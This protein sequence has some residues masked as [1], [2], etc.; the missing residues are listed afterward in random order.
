MDLAALLLIL[1]KYY[2]LYWLFDYD[3]NYEYP[4]K[5][6]EMTVGVGLAQMLVY[7]GV[8]AIDKDVFGVFITYITM[9]LIALGMEISL[10]IYY[11]EVMS[12]REPDA[13]AYRRQF[14]VGKTPTLRL[15]EVRVFNSVY[16][17]CLLTIYL[18]LA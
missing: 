16:F 9:Y 3:V 14:G 7:F 18:I 6:L 15:K 4:I 10:M 8:A 5:Q 13:Y 11:M 12:K 1:L 2:G 17:I